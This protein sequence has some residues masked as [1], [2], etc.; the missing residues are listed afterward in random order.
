ML[1]TDLFK[2]I[3]AALLLIGYVF[4]SVFSILHMA[5]MNNMSMPMAHCPYMAG[6][7]SLCQM[8][9][10]DHLVP[11]QQLSN[12]VFPSFLALIISATIFLLY[13]WYYSPPVRLL[14]YIRRH[15][16]SLWRSLYQFLFSQGILNPKYY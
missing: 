8:K 2:P 15:W 13:T 9:V 1:K 14:L 10:S 5:H 6:E 4:L 12:V 11:W 16:H 3:V 7:P